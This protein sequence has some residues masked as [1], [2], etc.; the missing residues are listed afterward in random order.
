MKIFLGIGAVVVIGATLILVYLTRPQ[1]IM[2]V[3]GS[4]ATNPPSI[5]TST[6]N[7]NGVWS[8]PVT[9]SPTS[10]STETMVTGEN[11]A[12][13]ATR[14]FIHDASTL[15]DPSNKGNYY[16]TGTSTNGFA[17]GYR[18]PAQFFTIAL[19]QEPIGATRVA[20]ENF[21]M[22]SLGV[23]EKQLCDLKYYVGTDVHT[24][25]QYAGKQLGFSFCPGAVTL[26]Q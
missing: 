19:E 1:P 21:L 20:A 6:V 14:D 26:P 15:P 9:T 17:I 3:G 10:T 16:L 7:S 2:P 23:T 5:P 25:S 22:Q 8:P 4:T 11:G 18:L 24:N 12:V 13:I